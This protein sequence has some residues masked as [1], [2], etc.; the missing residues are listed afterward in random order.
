MTPRPSAES[1][2]SVFFGVVDR[3]CYY[4]FSSF[5]LRAIIYF[6]RETFTDLFYNTSC[7]TFGA[8]WVICNLPL[9]CNYSV[10]IRK[11]LVDTN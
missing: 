5:F 8:D 1:S 9:H 10:Y 6:T 7:G 11:V 2:G 4:S 3:Q